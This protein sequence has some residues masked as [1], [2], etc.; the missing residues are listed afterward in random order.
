MGFLGGFG[1]IR[2]GLSLDTQTQRQ[3]P[4]AQIEADNRQPIRQSDI[5]MEIID[6]DD[7]LRNMGNENEPAR[8]VLIARSEALHAQVITTTMNGKQLC[9]VSVSWRLS[10]S[11]TS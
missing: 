9:R 2:L 4:E 11:T 7:Q 8:A 10:I 6:I 3:M 1:Y 5:V